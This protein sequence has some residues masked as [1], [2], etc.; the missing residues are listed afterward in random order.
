MV[1]VQARFR[2]D[3]AAAERAHQIV[4]HSSR[5]ARRTIFTEA[6]GFLRH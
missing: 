1:K 5:R 2:R 4:G 3:F 6:N